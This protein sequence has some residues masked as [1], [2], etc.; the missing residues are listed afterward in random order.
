MAGYNGLGQGVFTNATT[1]NDQIGRQ[2][3]EYSAKNRARN[4]DENL[5]VARDTSA[6][7]PS[8]VAQDIYDRSVEEFQ[9]LD[10]VT[11]G[12]NPDFASGRTH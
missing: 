9:D 8:F 7:F 1:F 12:Y 4:V 10:V 5:G 6:L 3:D 2:R 11:P